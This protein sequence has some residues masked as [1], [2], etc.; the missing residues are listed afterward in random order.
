M[1]SD[2]GKITELTETW[3]P[4][5]IEA[6]HERLSGQKVDGNKDVQMDSTARI[7]TSSPTKKGNRVTLSVIYEF[8]VRKIVRRDHQ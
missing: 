8:S 1:M 6:K 3:P 7:S 5:S 4:P 2:L